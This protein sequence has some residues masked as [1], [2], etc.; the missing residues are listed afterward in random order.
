MKHILNISESILL[1]ISIFLIVFSLTLLN[2][3]YIKF[4]L[5]RYNYY[6]KVVNE[7]NNEYGS[8]VVYYNDVKEDIN[9]YVDSYYA[10]KNYTSRTNNEDNT[11]YN[12]HIKFIGPFKNI[13]LY[14]DIL[15]VCTILFI[16]RIR[17]KLIIL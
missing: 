17:T 3:N 6:D 14:R 5:N 10:D 15:D 7:I 11:I 16:S 12:N 4:E 8:T 13:R 1:S 2:K 9:N